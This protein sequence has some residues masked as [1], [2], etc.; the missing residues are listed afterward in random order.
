MC[1]AEK[2][3][4]EISEE[5]RQINYSSSWSSKQAEARQDRAKQLVKQQSQIERAYR[6]T[7]CLDDAFARYWI[8][9]LEMRSEVMSNPHMLHLPGGESIAEI[10]VLYN[11]LRLQVIEAIRR[12]RGKASGREFRHDIWD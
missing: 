2:V 7:F 8:G 4:A 10:E 11:E 12:I 1:Q 6:L 9:Y 3:L 5:L